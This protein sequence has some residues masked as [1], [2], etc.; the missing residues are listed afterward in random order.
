MGMWLAIL[1]LGCK[2]SPDAQHFFPVETKKHD[3]PTLN[4]PVIRPELRITSPVA[5]AKFPAKSEI[6]C[7]VEMRLPTGGPMP[8]IVYVGPKQGTV[9]EGGPYPAT[10]KH[11]DGEMITLEVTFKA[12]AYAGQYTLEAEA[13][14]SVI[15]EAADPKDTPETRVTRTRSSAVPIEV[16]P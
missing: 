4:Q 14:Q 10:T 5:S 7:E 16:V 9:I 1:P 11:R 3:D 15:I 2:K 12:P 8:E 13:L 6:R